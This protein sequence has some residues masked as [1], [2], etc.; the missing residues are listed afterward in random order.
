MIAL[1]VIIFV[2]VVLARESELL[3]VPVL[4]V[5][6]LA[7]IVLVV[8]FNMEAIAVMSLWACLCA[9]ALHLVTRKRKQALMFFSFAVL[10]FI[11]M[12]WVD[13]ANWHPVN[14]LSQDGS[15]RVAGTS[16]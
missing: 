1:F 5:A 7:V 14:Q 12:V 4:A 8:Y 9:G 11:L 13:Y 15:G 2:A 10:A 16:R 6:A 3:F